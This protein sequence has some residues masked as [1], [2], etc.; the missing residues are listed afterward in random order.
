VLAASAANGLAEPDLQELRRVA[1]G[2]GTPRSLGAPL[3]VGYLGRLSPEKGTDELLEVARKLF[4]SG[5]GVTLDI[6]GDGPERERLVAASNAMTA[7]GFVRF[8]GTVRDTTSFLRDIDVLIIP[9]HNEGMPYVLLEGMAAGCS[10]VAFAVGGIPEVISSPRFGV[11]I[12]PGDVEA[13][14]TAVVRFADEPAL[15]TA[16]GSA[17]SSHIERDFALVSRLPALWH[18]YGLDNRAIDTPIDYGEP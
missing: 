8:R 5:T 3:R 7:A 9:S 1:A 14:V 6:A 12:E 17:A 10:I 16:I 11:L 4:A 18:A 15:V 2:R 13:L